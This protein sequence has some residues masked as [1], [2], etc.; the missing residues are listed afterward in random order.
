MAL[1]PRVLA[2]LSAG[3][4]ASNTFD[5]SRVGELRSSTQGAWNL[6]QS[7][8][9]ILSTGGY[10]TAGLANKVGQNISSISQGDAGG[11]L[12]LINPLS[13]PGA[14]T[15]GVV[16]RRTYSQN[17][18]DMGVGDNT[19]TWLGLALDIGLDPTTY[20]TGGT[21]AG[22][23][24]ATQVA[25][26]GKGLTESQKIGNFLAGVG[27]GYQKGKANY[28]VTTTTRKLNA[29][30]NQTR[31]QRLAEKLATRKLKAEGIQTPIEITAGLPKRS[32]A[33]SR[34]P[35]AAAGK[36]DEALISVAPEFTREAT[37]GGQRAAEAEGKVA[38]TF[39][40]KESVDEAS[41]AAQAQ[42]EPLINQ[43]EVQSKL[44]EFAQTVIKPG[45]DAVAFA[46]KQLPKTTKA[47]LDNARK[48]V[49]NEVA[50]LKTSTGQITGVTAEKLNRYARSG[51]AS[52]EAAKLFDKIL[53][54]EIAVPEGAQLL[55]TYL[56]TA[57][58][59]A[60]ALTA[61]IVDKKA[62][63]LLKE[64]AIQAFEAT[65]LAL[66]DGEVLMPKNRAWVE[67]V[68]TTKDA[69]DAA[70]SLVDV[71]SP[72]LRKSS[73][74]GYKA[75]SNA[76]ETALARRLK[77][78][79]PLSQAKVEEIVAKFL[80]D[81]LEKAVAS[82]TPA[83]I[84]KLASGPETY[85]DLAEFSAALQSG[86]L[87][88]SQEMKQTLSGILGL[89]KTA[90]A[91]KYQALINDIDTGRVFTDESAEVTAVTQ[92]TA[93]V[94][95]AVTSTGILHGDEIAE[96]ADAMPS[97]LSG[98]EAAAIRYNEILSTVDPEIRRDFESKVM[99]L[100]REKDGLFKREIDQIEE[101]AEKLGLEDTTELFAK[102]MS[103]D[104]DTIRSFSDEFTTEGALVLSQLGTE[105]RIDFYEK[106]MDIGLYKKAEPGR[107]IGREMRFA[108]AEELLRAMGIPVRSSESAM[109]AIV[110]RGEDAIP[111][112]SNVT[113]GDIV[114]IASQ[115]GKSDLI[116]ALRQ[117]QGTAKDSPDF[118]LGNFLP[119]QIEAAW[120]KV[121]SILSEPNAKLAKGSDD[122]DA[123][124]DTLDI[125]IER[126]GK[127]VPAPHL[128]YAGKR[129]AAAAAKVDQTSDDLI[130][131]MVD[132][133]E[134]LTKLDVSRGATTAKGI[135]DAI[136]GEVS[137]LLSRIANYATEAEKLRAG[138]RVDLGALV[139]PQAV[140]AA[141]E[142]NM[143]NIMTDIAKLLDEMTSKF[144]DPAL[145]EQM[146]GTFKSLFL[147]AGNRGGVRPVNNVSKRLWAEMDRLVGTDKFMKE[148]VA[149]KT[150]QAATVAG[151]NARNAQA[152][153][154]DDVNSAIID[155]V[156]AENAVPGGEYDSAT[157]KAQ[158][159]IVTAMA[160]KQGFW[161]DL[162]IKFDGSR[163]MGPMLK[164]MLNAKEQRVF[165][166][167]HGANMIVRSYKQMYRGREAEVTTAFKALQKYKSEAAAAFPEEL[168]L[169]EW[170]AETGARGDVDLIQDLDTLLAGLLG[171]DQIFGLIKANSIMPSELARE[172]GKLGFKGDAIF[173]LKQT[174][175]EAMNVDTFW[176]DLELGEQNPFDFISGLMFAISKVGADIELGVRFEK[177]LG[178][179][180]AE[181]KAAG[182]D[183]SNWVQLDVANSGFVGSII[184]ST[185]KLFHVDDLER[186]GAVETYLTSTQEI[187]GPALQSIID[188]ADRATYV[189]KASNTLIRPGHWVVSS[190]GEAAMNTLAG[191]GLRHYH[192]GARLLRKFYPGLYDDSGDAFITLAN[193]NAASG[194]RVKADEFENIYWTPQGGARQA[195]SEEDIRRL[196]EGYGVMLHGGP[197]IEDFINPSKPMGK[198]FGTMQK[199][200]NKLATPAAIR[201]NFFRL[202]HFLHEL[203]R[204]TGART[205]DEAA[206]M[207]AEKVIKWH[208]TAGNLSAFEKTYMRRLVYFYTWQRTA[209]T[210]VLSR[211]MEVPGVATIPSKMQYALADYN[212]FNPESF[213]DPWD[214]DGVYASWHTG[215]LWGPQFRDPFG[216]AGG[217]VV[218]FQV[219]IQPI[220]VIGQIFKPFT[221]QPGQSPIDSVAGGVNDLYSSN[222]NPILKIIMES[223][224]QSRLGEGGDLP[225]PP[226]YLLNQVGLINTLS[227]VSGIGQDPNPYET[228]QE[229][230][231]KDFRSWMNLLLGQRMMDYNTPS[232]QYKWRLDQQETARRLAGQ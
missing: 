59:T 210:T 149:G 176:H 78:A 131:L 173:N 150:G 140:E 148:A 2:A 215:Q 207:A 179:T 97:K 165:A 138:A 228:P 217:D 204:V 74:L 160:G 146:Y 141:L 175:D 92:G 50:D 154:A 100:L 162:L 91:A 142:E 28:K 88:V 137:S 115:S 21:L 225:S 42:K 194:K 18:K 213:G 34:V 199:G 226:E 95:D 62:P 70:R 170:L 200:I 60:D 189:L 125:M 57:G 39:A 22:V 167:S 3:A 147:K 219:A 7:I 63:T 211:V 197:G 198:V 64:Q 17:L 53:D 193:R 145:A 220:D 67:G 195:I 122:W 203:E 121:A 13:V 113:Y 84:Q 201:D 185:D 192:K 103:G 36:A 205:L 6:G 144:S 222:L 72:G 14:I 31:Q 116:S 164:T 43:S 126:T 68:V 58:R 224:T 214:P 37:T 129:G 232:T 172:L 82:I 27:T 11:F 134:N 178:R 44:N 101:L 75:I 181:L 221:L 110:R 25:K 118:K 117:V 45:G 111:L 169:A 216:G 202:P 108:A 212:G 143:M 231:E 96:A 166:W 80:Q 174:G 128:S 208:P 51:L 184:G 227:K 61:V 135:G 136:S 188:I 40:T 46:E 229:K 47:F 158:E 107:I 130:Q 41:V 8:I 26:A 102:L 120:L 177:F 93:T 79:E 86:S 24:G 16:E 163:V 99:D 105:A 19:A 12:D 5:P 156:S 55:E 151:K 171:D 196:A 112:S 10:A 87:K 48:V 218:G 90:A 119:T 206:A 29:A 180:P 33:A 54:A 77:A 4:S 223:S 81:G 83:D 123:V 106:V 32:S 85:A 191:V 124:K 9:D 127:K 153:K 89:P 20:I 1:D 76:I 132:N 209:L 139:D 94:A 187:G 35:T 52:D 23:K 109:A 15:K 133:Y 69:G 30:K 159:G 56:A 152:S 98:Q 161:K 230:S 104:V 71:I 157:S 73:P 65:K 168:D 66:Q 186:L 190:V 114:Y 155:E 182:E 183:M 49:P 38:E